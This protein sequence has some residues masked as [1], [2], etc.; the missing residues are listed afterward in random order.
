MWIVGHAGELVTVAGLSA[1]CALFSW[2]FAVPGGVVLLAWA[3]T[4]VQ[5]ARR[6]RAVRAAHRQ[7]TITS[8]DE[9]R[10][11]AV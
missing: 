2:W 3:I 4:E 6:L 1:A 9:T 5:L 8:T 11:A 10:G 7:S